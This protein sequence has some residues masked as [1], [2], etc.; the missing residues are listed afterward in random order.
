MKIICI[1]DTHG[2]FPKDLP[3]GDILIH[4]G[5]WSSTGSY[6]DTIK[7]LDY[8]E[9]IN[10]NYENI[11]IVPGNHE[12]WIEDN[13]NLAKEEFKNRNITLLIDE[14]ITINGLVFY[15]TPW[16]PVYKNWSFMKE[17]ST[18]KNFMDAIP[19]ETDILIT[20]APPYGHLDVVDTGKE[21]INVGC[22]HLSK[23]LDRCNAKLHVFGHVH[24]SSGVKVKNRSLL[25]NASCLDKEYKLSNSYKVV[26]I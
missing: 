15:G 26:Y 2:S 21:K 25:V 22:K 9:K 3:K 5:D 8:L 11:V 13:I 6:K 19:D 1:S 4:A 18:R 14:S 7:F 20:H 23:A 24:E 10:Y 12:K 17:D 16:V